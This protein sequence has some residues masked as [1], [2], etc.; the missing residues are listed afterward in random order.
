[1]SEKPLN[2]PEHPSQN[3][4]A[5]TPA[6]GETAPTANEG[7]NSAELAK[8]LRDEPE[9][10][11]GIPA[12]LSPNRL[13]KGVWIRRK[14]VAL[15][16]LGFLFTSLAVALTL[17]TPK[18]DAITTLIM[19]Q[20]VEELSVGGG[21]PYQ[22]P[23][24]NLATMLDTLKLPSS[25]QQT[26]DMS[27]VDTKLTTLAVA[28]DVSIAKNSN[29]LN[30]KVTWDDP[31]VAATIVNNLAQVFIQKTRQIRSEQ[32]QEDFDRYSSQL[33]DARE[34]VK[35]A[36]TRVLA[37]QQEF[38]IS[39]IEEEIKARLIDLS[40][41][42]AEHATQLSEI[43]AL[44]IVKK[45]LLVAIEQ[46]PDTLVFS[47]LFR[48]PLGRKLEEYRL[49]LEQARSR[50]TESNPKVM[51]LQREV[52]A[53]EKVIKEH[54]IDSAP[55]DTVSANQLRLDMRLMLHD[56]ND[57]LGLAEGTGAGLARSIAEMD[58]KLSYLNAREK[59]FMVL[60]AER[61]AA[62]QLENSLAAKAQE[63]RVAATT[64]EP[65]F[66][67][68]ETARPPDRPS[69]SG[70]RLLVMVGIILG[71]GSGIFLALV[72][73]VADPKIRERR[74]L[75]E[76]AE[77]EISLELPITGH[78]LI[79]ENQPSSN[80]AR[81]YRRFVNNLLNHED[82]SSIVI[83]SPRSNQGRSVV[84]Y[85][86]GATLAIKSQ[87]CLIVDGDVGREKDHTA[88]PGLV[89][90]VYQ[91]SK[92]ADCVQDTK[93]HELRMLSKGL[94]TNSRRDILCLGSQGM[95]SLHEQLVLA[96]EKTIYELPPVDEDETAL[97]F[98]A[99]VGKAV[100]VARSG[101][102]RRKETED[103]L[104]LLKSRNVKILGAVIVDVPE[105]RLE[106]GPPLAAA[107]KGLRSRKSVDTSQQDNDLA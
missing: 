1:M 103:M 44:K 29:V 10:S 13:I 84:A 58:E 59:E 96:P 8:L 4:P 9:A 5:W 45:E 79:D 77:V 16:F 101:E 43:D 40:R 11:R 49:E 105:E 61:D 46:E 36:D 82:F 32:A 76:L 3:A 69:S 27:G 64:S 14:V 18:W 68:V 89:D 74:E 41:L 94:L 34:R 85:N 7:F 33:A 104:A 35:E 99:I 38:H 25:L 30:L 63:A 88:A 91:R 107:L 97:E 95:R 93:V 21:R 24:Y 86:L 50:Y 57:R 15:T 42:Q 54:G 70:R 28:I 17:V 71:I 66:G 12:K 51:K 72:L 80:M 47:Q 53:L 78:P 23:E 83:I 98:A 52:D 39:N 106:D 31:R 87:P 102:T 55:E 75:A 67:V 22:P 73:E 37:F 19:R 100:I 81:A 48:N 65:P 60:T 90:V 2:S 20:D 6:H 92:L 26:L 56:L 62:R